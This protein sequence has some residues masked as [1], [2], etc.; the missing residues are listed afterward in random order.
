MTPIVKWCPLML[1]VTALFGAALAALPGEPAS[2]LREVLGGQSCPMSSARVDLARLEQ[3]RRESLERVRGIDRALAKPALAFE[4]GQTTRD[5]ARAWLEKNGGCC[6]PEGSAA[7]VCDD[8]TLVGE[9]PIDSLHVALDPSD[10]VVSLD[11]FRRASS[12]REAL[13][14]L[15]RTERAL[16]HRVGSVTERTGPADAAYVEARAFRRVAADF[17][18]SEYLARLSAMNFGAG[19]IRV[20]ETYDSLPNTAR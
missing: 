2:W 3:H 11:L 15:A 16:L 18:Y 20:R 8:V 14:Q 13:D 1:S 5:E 6:R 7:L 12:G 4:L 17:R 10:R 9:L 19:E